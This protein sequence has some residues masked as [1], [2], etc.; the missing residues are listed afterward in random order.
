VID[1]GA[2]NDP[3]QPLEFDA[4]PPLEYFFVG[5][6]VDDDT[7]EL[8]HLAYY[9]VYYFGSSLTD[10]ER[11]LLWACHLTPFIRNRPELEEQRKFQVSE[12]AKK[13]IADHGLEQTIRTTA[14]E[15][16][17]REGDK[18]FVNCCPKCE[19]LVRTPKAKLCLW[20]GHN[21]KNDD[22]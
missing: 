12:E 20:C 6:L 17:G 22:A 16:L 21:W 19:R 9:L 4:V 5:N 18:V 14:D 10:D 7:K 15:V 1:S 11:R 3:K 2:G 13:T 8:Y